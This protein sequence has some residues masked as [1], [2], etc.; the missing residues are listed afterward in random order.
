M[1]RLLSIALILSLLPASAALLKV[2]VDGVGC[3]TRQLAVRKIWST[4]PGVLSVDIQPHDQT[5]PANHRTFLISCNQPIGRD[6]LQSSLGPRSRFY[7]VVSVTIQDS[8]TRTLS[9]STPPSKV[10]P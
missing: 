5:T 8:P 2:E 6:T 7:Q 10:H 3:H 9:K 1:I 4:L